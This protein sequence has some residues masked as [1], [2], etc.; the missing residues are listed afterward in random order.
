MAMYILNFHVCLIEFIIWQWIGG[1][2]C[3]TNVTARY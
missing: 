1:L 3:Y 2:I